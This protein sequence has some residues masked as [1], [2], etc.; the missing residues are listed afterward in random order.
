MSILIFLLILGLLV[1][2]H[3]FGHFIV[4]K[5]SGVLVEEFGIGFPPRIFSI[6]IGETLYSLN[7][8]PLGGFVRL[9]GEEYAEVTGKKDSKV[10][11]RA[12]VYKPPIKKAAIVLA[13]VFMNLLLGIVIYYGLI[14]HNGF[15]SEPIPLLTSYHF[16]FGQQEG[17]V[18]ATN[19]SAGSP[20]EQ[21]GIKTEDLIVAYRFHDTQTSWTAIRSAAELISTI[22]QAPGLKVDLQTENNKN[23]TKRTFTVIPQYNTKL[24]R[25][26]IGVNLLDTAVI[27]YKSPV[28]KLLSGPMHSYNILAYN[29][30]TIKKLFGFAVK[31]KS[32]GPVSQTVSGPIGI[33]TVI[34]DVVSTSGSK[35]V[36]NILNIMGLLSLSLGFMNVLPFP[37]LDGGRL[38]FIIYEWVTGRTVNKRFEE[39]VNL[40]G[41]VILILLAILVSVNDVMRILGK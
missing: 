13:G 27:A 15:R 39:Y 37:A 2:I 17:R 9:F 16:R 8:I 6:R 4:A 18:I 5:K 29:F 26:I 38:I 33:F 19:I 40:G 10:R 20:A 25:A 23:G 22:K 35:L 7:L 21:A 32:I 11:N 41:F 34:K 1:L 36:V 12:F 28:E 31:E 3:E 24:G 14:A 30:S